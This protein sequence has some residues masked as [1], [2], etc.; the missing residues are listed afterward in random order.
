[1][2]ALNGGTSSVH[3]PQRQERWSSGDAAG[4]LRRPCPSG[5]S[6][7]Q[8]AFFK[9]M[10]SRFGLH[11]FGQRTLRGVLRFF[12]LALI[13]FVLVFWLVFPLVQGEIPDWIELA[14]AAQLWLLTWVVQF[15]LDRQQERLDEVLRLKREGRIL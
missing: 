13:A 5:A 8:E 15:E 11:Q 3:N 12:L 1:M 9:T 6:Y 7:G 2:V 14:R 10:K 4:S